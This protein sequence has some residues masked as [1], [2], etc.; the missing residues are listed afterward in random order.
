MYLFILYQISEVHNLDQTSQH[1]KMSRRQMHLSTLG[2]TSTN[3]YR[4]IKLQ[5]YKVCSPAA[6]IISDPILYQV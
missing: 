6:L 4:N 5:K 3:R 2:T 1:I